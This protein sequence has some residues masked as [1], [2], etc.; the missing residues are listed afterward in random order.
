M[1]RVVPIFCL[2][3]IA[4]SVLSTAHAQNQPASSGDMGDKPLTSGSSPEFT[5]DYPMDRSGIL[6]ESA[7]W[8]SAKWADV[9]NQNPTK[10]KISRGWAASLSYGVVPAKLVA[11]YAG[12][13]APTQVETAQPVFCVCHIISLPGE[14]ALVR[15]HPKKGSRE[16]DGG[17]MIVYPIVGGSKEAD[18][19]SSDLIP[20]D[21][22]HPDAHVWLIRP[23]TP[24][25]PGEYA[26][27]LGTQNMSVFPFTV[28]ASPVHPSGAN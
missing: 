10:N 14:L 21:T 15:L 7:K 3:L 2:A 19:N 23:Q 28:V 25:P 26:L 20:A 17:R 16:L 24:L 13:H 5:A 27:M 6:I 18:A 4:S 9:A 1:R 8:T 12:E 22:S 11:E